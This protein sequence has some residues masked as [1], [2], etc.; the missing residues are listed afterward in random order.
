MDGWGVVHISVSEQMQSRVAFAS[1][2]RNKNMPHFGTELV[3]VVCVV[4]VVCVVRVSRVAR[5]VR[6]VRVV[7]AL[8]VVVLPFWT[9]PHPTRATRIAMLTFTTTASFSPCRTPDP[10]IT[11]V[12]SCYG[13]YLSVSFPHQLCVCAFAP[14]FTAPFTYAY[15][16][17]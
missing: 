3:R 16:S 17:K 13:S 7:R 1:L 4:C 12:R 6:A 10:Y 5:A 11:A 9:R 15:R 8:R 2:L 14:I